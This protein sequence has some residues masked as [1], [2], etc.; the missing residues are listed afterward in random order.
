[1]SSC[2]RGLRPKSQTCWPRISVPSGSARWSGLA[3]P[4]SLSGWTTWRGGASPQL[5]TGSYSAPLQGSD[6]IS[7]PYAGADYRIDQ[8]ERPALGVG[9]QLSRRVAN[10]RGGLL[11][12]PCAA[13]RLPD[14]EAALLREGQR[15]PAPDPATVPQQ[16]WAAVRSETNKYLKAQKRLNK[17]CQS[18]LERRLPSH[19]GDRHENLT[20][21][22]FNPAISSVSEGS[23][24]AKSLASQL[25]SG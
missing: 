13:R 18:R 23:S 8:H 16:I 15:N 5:L 25:Q 6:E 7:E 11:A 2:S 4:I 14:P 3:L 12:I 20:R 1:M 19:S 24:C 22:C 9:A 10:G 21:F 17:R